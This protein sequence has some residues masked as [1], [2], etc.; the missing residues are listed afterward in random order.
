MCGFLIYIN[1]NKKIDS[2]LFI[3]A[4]DQLKHRGPDNERIFYNNSEN[5]FKILNES[6]KT[7]SNIF[8]GHKRLSIIDLSD[9][10][11]QP[12][13][14]DEQNTIFCYNGEIYNFKNFGISQY[15]YS[16]TLTL[17][18]LIK[19]RKLELFK[20][21]NGA[22]AFALFKK[23]T[24]KILLSRDRYGKKP[25]YYYIKND[26]III[27]SEINP[28]FTILNSQ[29]LD[30]D[31]FGLGHYLLTKQTPFLNNGKTFYKD[32]KSILPGKIFELDIYDLNLKEIFSDSFNY[33]NKF[34]DLKYNETNK[35]INSLDNDIN[36]AVESRLVSDVPIAVLT[37]GGVDSTAI[38]SSLKNFENVKLIHCELY[39][40]KKNID[41]DTYFSKILAKH[42]KKEL[43][44]LNI[45]SLSEDDFLSK[46]INL[47][48]HVSLPLN[49][50]LATFPSYLISEKLNNINYKVALEGTGG[51][52]LMGGYQT[53]NKLLQASTYNL[54]LIRSLKIM[55]M[56]LEFDPKNKKQIIKFI[57]KY[58][59]KSILRIKPTQNHDQ[60]LKK[61]I[62]CGLQ[63]KLLEEFNNYLKYYFNRSLIDELI[64]MQIFEIN[65]HQIPFYVGTSDTFNM[66]NS[67][68]TRLPFLDPVL[69]KYLYIKDSQKFNKKYSKY[70]LRLVLQKRGIPDSIT[71][72]TNKQGFGSV[73]SNSIINNKKVIQNIE[74][75]NFIKK[76]FN[77]NTEIKIIEND[78]KR[79]LFSLAV[80]DNLKTL[81][82]N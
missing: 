15:E 21:I 11:I 47:I 34:T 57:V 9:R 50:H 22:W 78:N 44:T 54:K 39:D 26:T 74:D 40:N 2:D 41:N 25:L 7:N 62:K 75:S 20:K 46:S 13:Y 35:L 37:S 61:L 16:D 48:D 5:N 30:V 51:D 76:I 42:F 33:I 59:F 8:I 31:N 55:K 32:I 24:N 80:L 60:L 43:I 72:R 65:N 3:K 53:F 10:S 14:D 18:Y 1:K 70:L 6:I 38:I 29:S 81:N 77:K 69:Q 67:V 73:V 23:N 66:I 28:I 45:N 36:D 4:L 82:L 58:I 19:F 64:E 71:W 17:E 79:Q 52:E 49:L 12:I 56:W 68:E 63:K 27:C